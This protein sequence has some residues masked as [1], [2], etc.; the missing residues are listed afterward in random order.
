MDIRDAI[1][2][3][4]LPKVLEHPDCP[5]QLRND[6]HIYRELHPSG[7]W[8]KNPPTSTWWEWVKEDLEGVKFLP[9][10]LAC[11]DTDNQCP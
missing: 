11:T 4:I 2:Q 3:I 10:I 8:H 6:Y 9:E 5:R 7:H 1:A